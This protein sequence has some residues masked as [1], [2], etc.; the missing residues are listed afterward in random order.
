[1]SKKLRLLLELSRISVTLKTDKII[2]KLQ[3]VSRPK[4][5][6]VRKKRGRFMSSKTLLMIFNKTRNFNPKRNTHLIGNQF[7][8]A[9]KMTS[10]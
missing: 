10:K 4:R 2:R 5:T 8:N 9:K 7:L 6:E 1:M 3:Q